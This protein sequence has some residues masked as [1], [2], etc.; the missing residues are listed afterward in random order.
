MNRRTYSFILFCCL[1]FGQT[2]RFNAQVITFDFTKDFPEEE[3]TADFQN[4]ETLVLKMRNVDPTKEFNI[5]FG[6]EVTLDK[7]FLGSLLK[8]EFNLGLSI[9][10]GG[11]LQI[12]DIQTFDLSKVPNQFKIKIQNGDHSLILK[13]YIQIKKTG[14]SSDLSAFTPSGPHMFSTQAFEKAP[15][16]DAVNLGEAF[17]RQDRVLIRKILLK[18]YPKSPN[19]AALIDSFSNNVLIY[20]KLEG[21]GRD[22]APFQSKT[23]N[24]PSGIPGQ[25]AQGV[26]NGG[27]LS[28]T[29]VI[30]ALATL[31]A[32][33]FKDELNIAYIQQFQEHLRNPAFD[34]LRL[35]LPG[36]F[37]VLAERDPIQYKTYL[38]TLREALHQDVV[39][40]KKNLPSLFEAHEPAIR[41][42][43]LYMLIQSTFYVINHS[44][45][46]PADLVEGLFEQDF[47]SREPRLKA[48]LELLTILSE[49]LRADDTYSGWIKAADLSKINVEGTF[50]LFLGFLLEKEKKALLQPLQNLGFQPTRSNLSQLFAPNSKSYKSVYS[51]YQKI[52]KIQAEVEKFKA[53]LQKEPS[54][55]TLSAFNAYLESV[56]NL[57]RLVNNLGQELSSASL[58]PDEHFQTAEKGIAILSALTEEHY[59]QVIGHSVALIEALL[60]A[61]PFKIH[62]VR[63]SDFIVALIEAKDSKEAMLALETVAMPIGSYRIKRTVPMEVGINAYPGGFI[64]GETFH[65]SA[66]DQFQN[67][68]R[69][70]GAAPI[71][72][73][74][75]VLGFTTPIGIGINWGNQDY[76]PNHVNLQQKG[77]VGL[78]FSLIDIGAV[79]NFRLQDETSLLP[80]LKWSNFLA[81]GFYFEW[82]W[83]N[84][85]IS[86]G[87]GAQYGPEVR[88]VSAM[89][90]E[91]D[92]KSWR[93]G[94]SFTVDI[95][96]LS[97]YTKD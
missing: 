7:S 75:L 27:I 10:D 49:N 44:G 52:L 45:D 57:T 54:K 17:S 66:I 33:R 67:S 24:L 29:I 35:L 16:K 87:I 74:A 14:S 56:F 2:S 88:K 43:N 95:P 37:A 69:K 1:L 46:S 40:L 39:D 94:I 26:G 59:A 48:S 77:S 61:S 11:K 18:Y 60:P 28:P 62:F 22:L 3:G 19:F 86:L 41:D 58:I 8:P 83:K 92:A 64:G 81:P 34:D 51:T 5:T 31:I 84:S 79:V 23:G 4:T 30:D 12:D 65:G 76:Q 15:F 9:L 32:K 55:F 93:A 50:Q 36:A 25:L 78:F 85:P 73:S 6:E 71:D 97:I 20:S 82:G 42:P 96:V 68:L 21:I 80:E 70:M 53:E 72:Q 63:Y 13:N 47:F 91:T 89:E 90:L 38:P